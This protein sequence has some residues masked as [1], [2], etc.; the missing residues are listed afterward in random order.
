M[1]TARRLETA[2]IV[3]VA[4]V[5]L[6]VSLMDLLGALDHVDW[7][8]ERIP[9]LTLLVSGVAVG[10]LVVGQITAARDLDTA[11]SSAMQVL[12]DSLDGVQV[13]EFSNRAEFWLYAAQAIHS[14]KVSVDDLTWG[15]AVVS[16]LSADDLVAYE[17]YRRQ[18]ALA[19]DGKGDHHATIFRELMSYPNGDRIPYALALMDRHRYPNYH[20]KYYDFDHSGVPPFL[21]F[22]VFDGTEVLISSPSASV[23]GLDSKYSAIKS[24]KLASVLSHYFEHSW[25]K[26]KLLKD[27]HVANVAELQ[28]IEA[29]FTQP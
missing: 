15:P 3:A 21:Q 13:K 28:Q 14:A 23:G 17:A 27:T 9:V 16:S 11:L 2:T 22:Y 6:L 1:T 18:I 26:A 24:A 4:A 5:A 12:V 20:L 25:R 29:D 10:Y 19:T 7:L 8:K